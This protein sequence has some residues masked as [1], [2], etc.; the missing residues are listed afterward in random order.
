MKQLQNYIIQEFLI[1]NKNYIIN[2][3]LILFSILLI[4]TLKSTLFEALYS[5]LYNLGFKE[6]S[7]DIMD[8]YVNNFF[9]KINLKEG[10]AI[11]YEVAYRFTFESILFKFAILNILL[12]IF[13][14]KQKQEWNWKIKEEDFILLFFILIFIG[15]TYYLY[16]DNN[17]FNVFTYKNSNIIQ[18]VVYII[19]IFTLFILYPIISIIIWKSKNINFIWQIFFIIV[20]NYFIIYFLA[21]CSV[22]LY[23]CTTGMN[24]LGI[25]EGLNYIL[26]TYNFSTAECMN[27]VSAQP[28]DQSYCFGRKALKDKA[29][30]EYFTSHKTYTPQEE[31]L[32]NNCEQL[33]KLFNTYCSG[34]TFAESK[35]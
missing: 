16:I 2:F 24:D 1:S 5:N 13:I 27:D 7:S 32:K 8:F 15:Y 30:Q 6:L 12:L 10:C 25:N 28:K 11:C 9:D 21:D 19:F 18:F 34:F 20:F 4:F 33:T 31:L 29:C 17:F 35:K 23:T 14:K 3:L 22:F 26:Q